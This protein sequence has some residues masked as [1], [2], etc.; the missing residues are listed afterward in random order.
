M[1]DA[2]LARYAKALSQIG[3]IRMDQARYPEAQAAFA[4][5]YARASALARRHPADG[6]MLFER[7]Q[8]EY[9]NGFVHWR[10]GEFAAAADWLKRYHDTGAALVA[11]DPARAAWQS[12]LA[13]GNHNLAVLAL[14]RGE[15]TAA[16]AGFLAELATLEKMAAAKPG[17]LELRFR[18]A[19]AHSWLGGLASQQGE[20]AEALKQY[21]SQVTLLEELLLAEPRTTRWRF[22]LADAQLY[23]AEVLLVTGRFADARGQLD[24]AR[25]L[26]DEVVAHDP[27]NRHWLVTSLH[28]RLLETALLRQRGDW[29]A[30]A[31]VIDEVR[32]G[33]E[34]LAAAEPSD[35][36]LARRTVWANR[37]EAQLAVSAGRSGARAA[38]DRAMGLGEELVH[39][40]QATDADVGECALACVVAGEIAAQAGDSAAARQDWERAAELLA[41]RLPN[42]RDWRLLDPAARA[43]AHLGRADSAQSIVAQLDRLGYVPA[44]PW[45]GAAKP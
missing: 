43:A 45:P 27:A 12:E 40:G 4:E 41:P 26:L 9:W 31:R 10:R 24:A 17:D 42:T 39:N 3:E 20:F 5:A 15:L 32:P 7:G 11:L 8:A 19:D 44:E 37:L 35:R 6:D 28:A 36:V 16:R 30:A 23:R 38:A 22:R 13:Y 18:V 34:K 1:D 14:Q 29:V 33:L 2:A 25:R 21:A